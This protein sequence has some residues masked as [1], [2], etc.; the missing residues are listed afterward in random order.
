MAVVISAVAVVTHGVTVNAVMAPAET[1]APVLAAMANAEPRVMVRPVTVVA[2]AAPMP[3]VLAAPA[4]MAVARKV[5]KVPEAQAKPMV[6]AHPVLIRPLQRQPPTQ[7]L[8]PQPAPPP[9]PASLTRKR[10]R[11][12]HP[13]GPS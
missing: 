4:V 2:Q 7:P 12:C 8:R 9:R 6:A 10:E 1:V 13:P 11:G 3:V 5:R